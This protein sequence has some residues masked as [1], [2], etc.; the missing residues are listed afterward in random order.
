[1]ELSII[2]IVN[3]AAKKG[4]QLFL[5]NGELKLKKSKNQ[6]IDSQLIKLLKENKQEIIEFLQFK[7]GSQ[8]DADLEERTILPI[9]EDERPEK[10]PLSFSQERLWFLDQLQGSEEYHIPIVLRLKGAIDISALEMAFRKIVERHEVLRTVICSEEGIGYQ[11][12][13]PSEQW[14]LDQ[15]SMLL[16]DTEISLHIN[17][18]IS[19]PFNLANDYMLRARLYGQ[20]EECI[21]VVVVHH[22][23]SDDWSEGILFEEFVELYSAF[24]TGRKAELSELSVQYTDYAIWQR[25][26]LTDSVLESQLNYWSERLVG[27]STLDVPT[28]YARPTVQSNKGGSVSN[29]IE[30][31]L[32]TGLIERSRESDVTMFMMLLTAFKVLLYRYSGQ[33]D[34]CV[35]IPIANRTQREIEPL[36][37]FF[38]NTVALRSD[39]GG[40]PVFTELLEQVKETTL[41]AYDHQEVPFEKVVDRVVKTRDMSRSPLFQVLFNFMVDDQVDDQEKERAD[42]GEVVITNEPYEESTSQFDLSFD[43]TQTGE[44][45][46]VSVSYCSDLYEEGTIV[47]MLS[48]YESLLGS[49]VLSPGATIGEL[50]LLSA[51]EETELLEVFN[52]SEIDLGNTEPINV[53]FESIVS[54]YGESTAVVHGMDSWSYDELNNYANQ[55]AHG[56]LGAG[57]SPGTCVGVY[58]DRS[59]VFLGCMMGIMKAGGVYVPLDT[60]NPP[61]RIKG[62]LCENN[63]PYLITSCDLL[64]GL[65]GLGKK[66]VLLVD[67]HVSDVALSGNGEVSVH[68]GGYLSGM[69]EGNPVNVNDMESWAYVLFTSGS[70]G[71]PKGAITRH[72]GAMN[73]LLAEY[74]L[75]DL[76]DGFRFLQS[77]GIGSDI[78]VWQMLGP[79]LKGG[80]CVMIDKMDLLDYDLVLSVIKDRGVNVVEFVPT[81]MWGLLEHI[82]DMGGAFALPSL[83][84][85]MLVGESIPVSM[86]NDL[87]ELYPGVRMVNAYGPCEASD[88]VIQYEI[89]EKLLDDTQRVPIGKL[90][91]NMNAVILSREGHLCP[92]G[93]AGEICVSG[94]GVGAGYLDLPERT[95]ESFVANPFAELSGDVLYK[96]GDLGRWLSDGNMEFLGRADD[97]VKIRGHRVE[98]E[99]IATVV[100]TSDYVEDS[101]VLVH[102]D[103]QGREYLLCFVTLS[104]M[105]LDVSQEVDISESLHVL[106]RGE[107]PSYMHPSHY[108]VVDSFPVN[109]SD[110]VDGKALIRTFLSEHGELGALQSAKYVAPGNETE[111]KLAE[112]WQDLLGVERVGVHDNFFELGG[113]SLL[114]TRLVSMVRRRMKIELAIAAIFNSPTIFELGQSLINGP[115]KSLLPSVVPQERGE[116]IP[117]SFSQ[118]RLWFLDQLQGTKEYHISM[119]LSLTG[120]L[121]VAVLE[122]CLKTIVDRHEVLRSVYIEE[123]GT[124]YQKIKSADHWALDIIKVSDA[125]TIEE[126]VDNFADAPFDLSK[127]YMFRACLY[128]LGPREYVLAGVFHHIASDGWSEGIMVSE[129]MEL[130]NPLSHNI[131]PKLPKLNVQYADYAIWQRKY[132]EGEVLEQQLEYW[133]QKL[134]GA[135]TLNLPIDYIR[136][137]SLDN[138]GSRILMDLDEELCEQL[139]ALSQTCGVT[140]Y[141]TL[142]SAFKV[143]LSRY[144]GQEDINVGT[145]IANRTQEALEGMIGFFVN[146]LVLRS[147]L[148][149]NPSFM[150]LLE[151]VKGTTLGAY[152]HQLAP[153]EKVVDRV[154]KTRDMILNPLFQV[155]FVL[156]NTPAEEEEYLLT[157]SELEGLKLGDFKI[158]DNTAQFD[159]TLSATEEESNISLYLEYRTG[160][161]SRETIEGM[162][163]HYVE[164]LR[165]IVAS[166]ESRLSELSMLGVSE[167]QQLLESLGKSVS[168]DV[169]GESVLELFDRH[170]AVSPDSPALVYG[171]TEL[172]YGELGAR[173]DRLAMHLRDH[174][175]IGD[176]DYIGVIQ[177]RSH[178]SVISILG[179]LKSGGVYVPIDAGYPSDRKSYIIEDTG[180]GLIMTDS[181]HLFDVTEYSLP[182]FTIDIEL[183]GLLDTVVPEAP[184]AA[185]SPSSSAYVIYTSGSTGRPKGVPI[186]HGALSN[187]IHNSGSSYIGDRESGSYM[188][189]SMS[190]DASLTELFTPLVSGKRLVISGREGLDVF[191]DGNLLKYAPYDFIKL[192]PSHM[193]LLSPVLESSLP[194]VLSDR[195]VLGGETLLPGHL[196]VFGELG[197]SSEIVNEYG[198]T[199]ATVG[200]STHVFNSLD[201]FSGTDS[202]SIGVPMGNMRIYIL[203]SHGVLLPKGVVGELCIGGAGVSDGYLNLPELNLEKFVDNP[204]VPGEKMYRTGDLGRWSAKGEIEFIGRKDDQVKVRGYRIELG[205]IESVLSGLE[206]IDGAC[207]LARAD[208]K[209]DKRLVGYVVQEGAHEREK[210]ERDLRE[211]L[212]E[213]M[214]PRLWVF[215]E[216]LPLTGNGKVD[217]KSLPDPGASLLSER[218]YAAPRNETEQ[219]LTDIWQELLGVDKVGIQDNFFEL[220]GDSIITIQ[221]VS[222]ARRLGYNLN[223]I[224]IFES[225]TISKL[226]DIIRDQ[227]TLI[228]GE[229]GLLE[230]E[231]EMLPIQ[232]QYFDD[233]HRDDTHFNQAILLGIDKSIP[234]S[235]F[236]KIAEVLVEHHDGLRFSYQKG[237]DW[238]QSYSST[239]GILETRNL[240]ELIQEELSSGITAICEEFQRGLSIEKGEVFKMVLMETPDY[241]IKN[242]LFLVANHLV[243]DGV[244]WRILIDD[245]SLLLEQIDSNKEIDLGKKGSSY[246]EWVNALKEY[247]ESKRVISQYSYWKSLQSSYSEIPVDMVVEQ[248]LY[249]NVAGHNVKLDKESTALLLQKTNQAYGTEINDILLCGLAMAINE[250]SGLEKIVVGLEGHGRE[251]ISN[252]IDVST[253]VGWFTNLYP[254]CLPANSG[255]SLEDFIKST[256]ETLRRVPGK[257]MGYGALRYLHPSA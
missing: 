125:S 62:M 67:D 219:R 240:K 181:E 115:R 87:R 111:E 241:E 88:D 148:G 126:L 205:E 37:G 230:G 166:P 105:G 244:S 155:F 163:S 43:I 30:G 162:L 186:T 256:K 1:M 171:V 253:T 200:C 143:L 54:D 64:S 182:I 122:K 55:V 76:D 198:P 110:K 164:L 47:R 78:S 192:T 172:S 52:G 70:T 79:V 174:Y 204:Y 252:N 156:Q 40:D 176:G 2:D 21:L 249:S 223:P 91:P 243:I 59:P 33:S 44:G 127:D 224:D 149:G 232:K 24:S 189:L 120:A 175:H 74:S 116:R 246:R 22:I 103:D 56:L 69:P 15:E 80:S 113:H 173:V 153:F 185:L 161:F 201:D 179:I 251:N 104:G 72:N 107:L 138:T 10:I 77:A 102:T 203:D 94:V 145:P 58:M 53:R 31:S 121:D 100:R 35:G 16:S 41:G 48:H 46:D 28:D 191:S 159:L 118:E 234:T 92:I 14:S 170:V 154:V 8:D 25:N 124:G 27:V 196:S 247:A 117:L 65:D 4:V 119:A 211:R 245:M 197:I 216:E 194:G 239:K 226:A 108:C 146:T 215:L 83:S 26:Y 60:Q 73:H 106:C 255:M 98:L 199:E 137:S 195:Y 152:D 96:T 128:E 242:R 254:I 213:Y 23:S 257:G 109:L 183:D 151:Q 231:S 169:P 131:E 233:L 61:S 130:Y 39:L 32:M 36:V 82:K 89:T 81:Y 220:G 95:A 20:P 177:D 12:I 221:V 6:E 193:E 250:W 7:Y 206:G 86:V 97:Q 18:F 38:L 93:V 45:L 133:E 19:V 150:E 63:F 85:I 217:R 208:S 142:L 235:S 218:E 190:F 168:G 129:F 139:L 236:S 90:I 238:K 187:Y 229:Q 123:E 11:Q 112:I 66:T 9:T 141:M 160:L 51:S 167:E 132:L 184:L 202:F 178:W 99:G 222:R 13:I 135:E 228:L 188:H 71:V 3:Q 210:L 50:E 75:M 158:N 42:L 225:Q 136:P 84:W 114:A 134:K 68:D 34:I 165:S 17:E 29:L 212:P 5:E 248:S 209:G 147:D 207:V 227:K 214:V 144:C 180:L 49:I 101:H 140:L 237:E 157:G 57:L